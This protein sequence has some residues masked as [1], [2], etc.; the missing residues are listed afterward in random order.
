MVRGVI[1][2]II[3][4]IFWTLFSL[5]VG[6]AD[7][8]RVEIRVNDPKAIISVNGNFVKASHYFLE[9]K[10]SPQNVIIVAPDKKP[11]VRVLPAAKDFD[12]NEIFWNIR[13]QSFHEFKPANEA[14][15]LPLVSTGMELLNQTVNNLKTTPTPVLQ[16]NESEEKSIAPV[17]VQ[18]QPKNQPTESSFDSSQIS[19]PTNPIK[20][21]QN[22]TTESQVDESQVTQTLPSSVPKEI[23]SAKSAQIILPSASRKISSITSGAKQIKPLVESV[24]KGSFLQI[25]AMAK[26]NAPKE[27]VQNRLEAVK[28]KLTGVNITLCSVQDLNLESTLLLFG[29]VK[30]QVEADLLTKRFGQVTKLIHDP[31][32]RTSS[33]LTFKF[34]KME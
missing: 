16:N 19:P 21:D 10:E 30:N 6:A 14:L 31:I 13:L 12:E 18:T 29:P 22:L 27:I 25:V 9:C 3:L 23:T 28:E 15:D 5:R 2:S 33:K 4:N 20:D 11:F 26:I 17:K 8:C 32:C 34:G 24:L 7:N 1:F